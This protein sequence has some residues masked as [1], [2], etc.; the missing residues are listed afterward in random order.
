[1]RYLALLILPLLIVSCSNSNK[2]NAISKFYEDGRTRP[3]VAIAPVV[4]STSYDVP[5]SLS[6]E[7]TSLIRTN[8]SKNKSIF[9]ADG[10][11]VANTLTSLDNPFNPD[12]SWMDDRFDQNEFIVFL[13]LVKHTNSKVNKATNLDM[14]MRVKVVDVRGKKPKVILQENINDKYFIAKGNFKYDY[15]TTKWGSKEFQ[16]SRMGMAH[17]QLAKDIA[18]RVSEYVSLSKSR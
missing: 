2:T 15:N 17:M 14:I 8:L 18:S 11:D 16:E 1:M 13:E 12:I 7:L 4:D 10:D 3:I 6:D 9:I 5:W